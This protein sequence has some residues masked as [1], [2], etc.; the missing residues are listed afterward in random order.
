MMAITT[1]KTLRNM[2]MYQVFVRNFSEEGTFNKVAEKLD[3]IKALGMDIIWLMPIHPIGKIA[4][5]GTLGS[6]YAISD[7]RAV[8]PEFGTMDDFKALAAEIHKRGM[9][10][11]IDV[12]YNHTS[13]DSLLSREHPEWFYHKEDGS[14][15]NRVGD[16]TDIIDLDYSNKELWDY[17]IETLKM[18]AEIVDGFRCDVAPLIPLAFWLKARQE[19][20]KVRPGCIW[21]SESV[22]PGFITYMRGRGI[23]ALSDGEL[24]Q[25]FD[26]CYDYDVYGKFRAYLTGKGTLEEYAEAIDRQEYT[27][28]ENYIKLRFLENHDQTRAGMLIP[29]QANLKNWTAFTFFQKGMPLVYAGQ[30]YAATHTPSLF[31]KDTVDFSDDGNYHWLAPMMKKLSQMRRDT[32]FTDSVYTV[33]AQHNSVLIATH[34]KGDRKAL[35]V[36]TVGGTDSIR[37][38]EVDF[39]DGV[40]TNLINGEKTEV[41]RGGIACNIDP[42]ILIK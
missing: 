4:R 12:V 18:W 8:N 40:Y 5:K 32:L 42:I 26:L 21:L 15:G 35:G 38:I 34:E 16:W 19:V 6:P 13:P 1:P 36:F 2:T 14:F 31:D 10:C 41:F 29:H 28:P 23:T 7:Y 3:D 9:K 30:E 25:A 20:E 24:Y 17:Q 22:E 37:Y 27:Y 39:P 11:I 33:K